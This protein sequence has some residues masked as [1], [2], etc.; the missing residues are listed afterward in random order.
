MATV[1]ITGAGTGIGRLGALTL[2]AAILVAAIVPG[3]RIAPTQ[4]AAEPET[5]RVPIAA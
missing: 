5:P 1:L 4:E 2:A 3:R